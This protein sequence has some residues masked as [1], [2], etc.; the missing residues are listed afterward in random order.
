MDPQKLRTLV[1]EKTGIKIDTTDPVF[2]LVA[3]N[4]SVLE[5]A[6]QRHLAALQQAHLVNTGAALSNQ[7]AYRQRTD[8]WESDE[9]ASPAAPNSSA[10]SIPTPSQ[11]AMIPEPPLPESVPA[12]HPAPA[13]LDK[14][15]L[16]GAATVSLCSALLVLAGQAMWGWGNPK[17]AAPPHVLPLNAQ[18]KQQLQQ[19]EK[20]AR[21]L[22]KLDPKSRAMIQA[23]L[24][25]P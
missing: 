11:P 23:E 21:A 24:D 25:K 4:E 13:P 8:N 19:A 18:Q 1:F 7:P 3:L 12:A 16:I 15:L 22:E 2:A 5:E 20:L 6:L 10:S 14:R 17:S 9:P